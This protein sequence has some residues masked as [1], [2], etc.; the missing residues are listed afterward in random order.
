VDLGLAS[1]DDAFAAAFLAFS[2]VAG[3]GEAG[4]NT[5]QLF[6]LTFFERRDLENNSAIMGK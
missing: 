4:A 6:Q 5:Y 3:L 2:V 1:N